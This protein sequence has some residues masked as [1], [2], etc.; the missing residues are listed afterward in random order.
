[1]PVTHFPSSHHPARIGW[2][3]ASLAV[4]VLAMA[5]SAPAAENPWAFIEKTAPAASDTP[6]A[7]PDGASAS[8]DIEATALPDSAS[9]DWSALNS[10]QPPLS[11]AGRRSASR[12]NIR[13][14]DAAPSAWSRNNTPEGFSSLTVKQAVT[15]F[16][17][18]RV[19]ADMNVASG[20]YTLAPLPEKLSTD[21]RLSQ[22]SGTAW[23][24]MTAPGLGPVW[25]KTAIEAR[26]DPA[27]DTSRLG[28][29]ISKSLP[30]DGNAYSLTLEGGY[31]VIEQSITP[32]ARRA[33]RNYEVDHAA[34]LN[35]ADT[36][37][38]FIAGQSYSAND[39]KWLG[40]VGAEQKL[41]GGVSLSG[42]VSETAT[43][44]LN[45]SLTAGF[46]S[47]W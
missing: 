15:P 13:N 8:A 40:R 22:S 11:D 3:L 32:A 26:L 2:Q 6:A 39:D 46:K 1:M 34:K 20:P 42:Q 7:R 28:T 36:G 45:K 43:G 47:N 23:A 37:T 4:G 38:S 33:A 27:Q 17:D 5:G 41:F 21:A 18:T 25:D 31:H 12:G 24:S 19:G 10:G 14:I 30:L 35:I 16:W 9:V 29:S 44:S